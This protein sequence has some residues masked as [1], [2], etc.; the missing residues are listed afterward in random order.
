MV[1]QQVLW[2]WV[3]A[4]SL[5]GTTWWSSSKVTRV[6]RGKWLF[7]Y[8]HVFSSD[9]LWPVCC[10]CL[11][12]VLK[13]YLFIL[14]LFFW[15]IQTLFVFEAIIWLILAKYPISKLKMIHKQDKQP[16]RAPSFFSGWDSL[17]HSPWQHNNYKLANSNNLSSSSCS[18][19]N[20][21][22][23]NPGHY[24]VLLPWSSCFVVPWASISIYWKRGIV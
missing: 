4:L 16:I 12:F 15:L 21:Q 23:P 8:V 22:A 10:S 7:A 24:P 2:G 3:E 14:I 1:C 11:L 13:D 5:L 17:S 18:V 6:C 20:F 9:S 19:F